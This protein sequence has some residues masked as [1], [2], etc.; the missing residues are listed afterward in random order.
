MRS[1]SYRSDRP[2]IDLI[3]T[4]N[5]IDLRSTSYRSQIDLISI[6]DR[7][8]I[9]LRSTSYRSQLFFNMMDEIESSKLG[10]SPV[11]KSPRRRGRQKP[12]SSMGGRSLHPTRSLKDRYIHHA[13]QA[14][15]NIPR[16]LGRPG[17]HTVPH[18]GTWPRRLPTRHEPGWS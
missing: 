7:P 1:T 18:H 9:D 4:Y 11:G 2:H 17:E 6:S 8:H 5:N 13:N 15:P 3:S 12:P 16:S 10:A 14:P